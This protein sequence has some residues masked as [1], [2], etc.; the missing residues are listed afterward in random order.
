MI[1]VKELEER[2]IPNENIRSFVLEGLGDTPFTSNLDYFNA[3]QNIINLAFIYAYACYL[4]LKNRNFAVGGKEGL[5]DRC[6]KGGNANTLRVIR[7]MDKIYAEYPITNELIQFTLMDIQFDYAQGDES[8]LREFFPHCYSVGDG[9]VQLGEYFNLINM[10]LIS[11]RTDGYTLEFLDQKLYALIGAFPFLSKASLEYSEERGWYVFKINNNATFEDG[12]I[13]T[14]GIIARIKASRKATKIFFLSSIEKDV[15]RYENSVGSKYCRLAGDSDGAWGEEWRMP[16]REGANAPAERTAQ[17]PLK[18]DP[19]QFYTYIC[20]SLLS[21][22]EVKKNDRAFDQLF[23]INYKYVKNLA[24]AISD[25]LGMPD[26]EKC[27]NA[28]VST[29]RPLYPD[30]FS[31]DDAGN[32]NWD[33]VVV[34]LL[35]EASPSRVLKAIL[36]CDGENGRIGFTIIRNLRK[37]FG[38]SIDEKFKD[39]GN[40]R[41]LREKAQRMV[42]FKAVF[43]GKQELKTASYDAIF[44]ELLAEAKAAI[45]LSAFIETGQEE[46]Y[47]YSNRILQSVES[48]EV[49]NSNS[50]PNEICSVVLATLGVVLKRLSCFY[51]GVYAYGM[52]K[53][54]YDKKSEWEILPSETI[55]KY[56]LECEESFRVAAKREWDEVVSREREDSILDS[57]NNFIKVCEKCENKSNSSSEGSRTQESRCLYEVIG[58]Y[59]VLDI[60][61]MK[62][63]INY[64]S[65]KE[66]SPMSANWWRERAIKLLRFFAIGSFEAEGDIHE[67]F[68]DAIAPTVASFFSFNN[69]KDGYDAATLY[70][71]IDINGNDVADFHREINVLSEFS[72]DMHSKYYCLPNVVR[73]NDKWWVEPFIIGYKILDNICRKE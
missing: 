61:M 47:R 19:E 30:A 39:I 71:T 73:A 20:P 51:S 63:E 41:D 21:K 58:R 54:E 26:N 66:L 57:L 25:A 62:R 44:G 50:D 8:L 67:F 6:I 72:F 11:S 43:S 68:Q 32:V 9:S 10:S 31:T 37:R 69:S 49:L 38:K 65:A 52:K 1:N 46:P 3:F 4:D 13:N 60:D 36:Q 40:N 23:N 5:L 7:T 22:N 48:L 17:I 56:Q 33:T 24:L 42:E 55:Q 34:M 12:M 2:L 35:I 16:K 15:L 28:L 29:F 27:C 18:A 64:D 14:Y 59:V 45:I 53:M 70:L